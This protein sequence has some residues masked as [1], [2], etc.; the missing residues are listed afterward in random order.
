MTNEIQNKGTKTLLVVDD[1]W[2]TTE[3]SDVLIAEW[4]SLSEPQING[5]SY[6]F[7]FEDAFDGSRYNSQKVLDRIANEP[8]VDG[9]ILDLDF[10][11]INPGL[12]KDKGRGY[13]EIILSS[14][15]SV[16]QTLPIWIHSST[17]DK[18]LKERCIQA[19]AESCLMKKALDYELKEVLDRYFLRQSNRGNK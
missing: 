5:F 1:Q 14:I 15:K 13:G 18:A 11:D 16:Y 8:R 9:V 3:G 12:M 2:G 6:K 10:N 7:K 4:G 17:N 19:G